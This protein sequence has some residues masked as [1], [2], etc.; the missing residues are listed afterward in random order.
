M[1]IKDSAFVRFIN[2]RIDHT[3][4]FTIQQKCI[5]F[6]NSNIVNI[7]FNHLIRHRES[8]FRSY[9][10]ENE[11]QGRMHIHSNENNIPYNGFS[12]YKINYTGDIPESLIDASVVGNQQCTE[13]GN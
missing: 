2:K 11:T 8:V 13:N 1:A 9:F 4:M 5:A 3:K 6:I 10:S 12:Y 7:K